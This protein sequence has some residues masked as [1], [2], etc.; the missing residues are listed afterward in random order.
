VPKN[1]SVRFTEEASFTVADVD[2]RAKQF[3]MSRSALIQMGLEFIM[4]FDPVL[5]DKINQLSKALKVPAWLVVQNMLIKRFAQDAARA[6][7]GQ[8][9]IVYDEFLFTSEGVITGEEL[10]EQIKQNEV[11]RLKG[12]D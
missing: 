12:N 3:N 7:M 6:E 4:N 5:L 10:F 8:S 11:K 9:R 1:I 2:E